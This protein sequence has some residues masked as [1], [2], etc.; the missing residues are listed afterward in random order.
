VVASH[1]HADHI[2]GMPAV[3]AGPVVRFYMDNGLATTTSTYQR[4]I[5]A[6]QAS[7]A[8]YLQATPRSITLGYARLRIL[9]APPG[10]T[11]QN[12]ASVGIR[13]DY[14]DFHAYLTGD[15]ERE[16]IEYWLAHAEVTRAQVVKAGHHGSANGVTPGWISRTRPG[17]VVISVGRGNTYGHP[18]GSVVAAWQAAGAQVYRTDR[19][20]TVVVTARTD[21]RFS[22]S[23]FVATARAPRPGR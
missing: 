10:T 11:D 12:N 20:G 16:E 6:L 5:A 23:T 4:T 15:S 8:T 2:G 18:S 3:L 21:G 9:G 14:G 19:Q 13:I 1:N 22:V 7:G 17:V